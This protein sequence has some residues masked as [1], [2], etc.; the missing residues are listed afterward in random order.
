MSVNPFVPSWEV[1][2]G[3]ARVLAI[4]LTFVCIGPLIQI[5]LVRILFA[6]YDAIS[7][8]TEW[9]R[10]WMINMS[11]RFIGWTLGPLAAGAG[12]TGLIAGFYGAIFGRVNVRTMLVISLILALTEL[13]F[14]IWIKAPL[15]IDLYFHLY[16]RK[17]EGL[18]LSASIYRFCYVVSMMAC[19]K[20][21]DIVRGRILAVGSLTPT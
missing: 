8:T 7:G 3:V 19:W 11:P 20:V 17:P 6:C 16:A 21:I 10:A 14:F 15:L 2:I 13:I 5:A 18:W 12:F 4:T 1:L 9:G